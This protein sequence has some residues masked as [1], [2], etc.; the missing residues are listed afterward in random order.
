MDLSIHPSIHP[1]IYSFIHLPIHSFIRPSDHLS[2]QTC[3]ILQ[4]SCLRGPENLT[5]SSAAILLEEVKR[6][7]E[8]RLFLSNKMN[9]GGNDVRISLQEN[10]V[11]SKLEIVGRPFH[12]IS[13][14]CLSLCPSRPSVC[15]YVCLFS[16][17][18]LANCLSVCLSAC[19]LACLSVCPSAC[20]PVRNRN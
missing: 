19:L 12:A 5:G 3:T 18:A 15:L 7:E 2:I 10:R 14:V 6:D 1:F 11:S 9:R 20:L 17:S 4:K 13:S 16:L 8:L